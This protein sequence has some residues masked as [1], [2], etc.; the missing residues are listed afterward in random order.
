MVVLLAG[1]ESKVEI[2]IGIVKMVA[3][4]LQFGSEA[5]INS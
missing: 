4:F 2:G 5:V 1:V 3:L